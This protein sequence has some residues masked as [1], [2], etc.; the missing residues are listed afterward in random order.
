MAADDTQTINSTGAES[1]AA[2]HGMIG[3]EDAQTMPTVDARDSSAGTQNTDSSGDSGKGLDGQSSKDG[4]ADALDRFDKHPRFKEL[5]ARTKEAEARA[6][7]VEAELEL[8][9]AQMAAFTEEQQQKKPQEPPKYK[10]ITTLSPEELL[11]WQTEKPLEYAANLYAQIRAELREEMKQEEQSAK[12]ERATKTV[13]EEYRQENPDF[14]TMWASGE[15]KKFMDTHPGHTPISAHMM[16]TREQRVNDAVKNAL[17]EREEEL[18]KQFKA[19]RNA[20][21]LGTGP[22]VRTITQEKAL[23]NTKAFGGLTSALAQRLRAFR[24]QTG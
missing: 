9:R 13:I 12:K 2:P 15:V 21:V 5:N 19:K 11:E 8:V 14:D 22:S 20:S 6:A 23:E 16:M 24:Q 17:K 4:D 18:T 3:R 1:S 10:D 7:K